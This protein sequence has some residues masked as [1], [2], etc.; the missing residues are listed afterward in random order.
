MECLELGLAMFSELLLFEI[1]LL[2]FLTAILVASSTI[3]SLG[4]IC[5]NFSGPKI[6]GGGGDIILRFN[7]WDYYFFHYFGEVLYVF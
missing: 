6:N 1:D 5:S 3:H 7:C 2:P 4:T